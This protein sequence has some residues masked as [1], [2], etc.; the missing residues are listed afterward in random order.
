MSVTT[1]LVSG[2]VVLTNGVQSPTNTVAASGT[3]YTLD[4]GKEYDITSGAGT[5]G[6]A[7]FTSVPASTYS[8]T[9]LR[10]EATGT[11]T[12]T[13]DNSIHSSDFAITRTLTNGNWA[14]VSFEIIPRRATNM[15]FVQTK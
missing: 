12:F 4:M 15:F 14:V 5:V 3:V 2:T 8:Y 13:N 6:V 1:L 10:V 7:T 9:T 11:V